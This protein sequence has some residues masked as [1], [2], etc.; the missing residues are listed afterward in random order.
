MCR[1]VGEGYYWRGV[2]QLI[3]VLVQVAGG[4]RRW[5]LLRV[6]VIV[7]GGGPRSVFGETSE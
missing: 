3:S 1:V 6:L 7:S 5:L 2:A 4:G